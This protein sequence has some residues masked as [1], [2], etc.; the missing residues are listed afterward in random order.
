M[1]VL[2]LWFGS[3]CPHSQ[4]WGINGSISS[5]LLS[6][7]NLIPPIFVFGC[8]MNSNAF[9]CSSISILK[10][11]FDFIIYISLIFQSCSCNRDFIS[12]LPYVSSR[13]GSK[14]VQNTVLF[15]LTLR[16]NL[17]SKLFVTKNSE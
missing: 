4:H 9:F 7:V 15:A 3:S 1:Q 6:S 11:F 5:S 12:S 2:E 10:D 8:L 13:A 14:F 16:L 17:G